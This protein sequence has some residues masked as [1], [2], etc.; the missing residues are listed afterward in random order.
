MKKTVN[1]N[2]EFDEYIIK[3]KQ[4]RF[5]HVA[6]FEFKS[7][8]K[9]TTLN[10]KHLDNGELFYNFKLFN[11]YM[12]LHNHNHFFDTVHGNYYYTDKLLLSYL[13]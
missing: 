7:L 6:D 1:V 4:E 9:K 8:N 12:F 13:F 10:Y 2:L 11:G 5:C 3:F